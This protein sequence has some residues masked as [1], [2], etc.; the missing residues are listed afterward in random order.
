M[1]WISKLLRL[2][3][4]VVWVLSLEDDS[5]RHHTR[6]PRYSATWLFAP[7]LEYIE[8]QHYEAEQKDQELRH[9]REPARRRGRHGCRL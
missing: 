4:Y 1:A 8:L 9:S 3:L 5:K 6:D 7:T 2:K